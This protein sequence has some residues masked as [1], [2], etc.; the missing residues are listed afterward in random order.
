MREAKGREAKGSEEEGR[1]GE[2]VS[3]S[4]IGFCCSCMQCP[5]SLTDSLASAVRA[6]EGRERREG[7]GREEKGVSHL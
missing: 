6:V 4:P 2:G 7:K 1:G 5:V 3:H